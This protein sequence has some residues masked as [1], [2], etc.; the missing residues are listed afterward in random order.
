M[1]LNY[2]NHF[3]LLIDSFSQR[4]TTLLDYDYFIDV[5][6]ENDFYFFI[7]LGSGF[8]LIVFW[9]EYKMIYV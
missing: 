2:D 8:I 3:S 5:D 9:K 1:T 4:K 7:D 6:F